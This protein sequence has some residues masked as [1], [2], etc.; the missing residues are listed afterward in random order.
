ML[1]LY[2]PIDTFYV[3]SNCCYEHN[4]LLTINFVLS[5]HIE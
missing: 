1:K 4:M 5:D 2:L 3:L